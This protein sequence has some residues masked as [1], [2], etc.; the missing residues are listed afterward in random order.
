MAADYDQYRSITNYET[1][2]DDPLSVRVLRDFASNINNYCRYVALFKVL[3]NPC[4]PAWESHDNTTDERVIAIY[5]PRH[6][7]QG[8]NYWT[9]AYGHYRSAGSGSTTWRLYQSRSLY[10]AD[11][12]MDTDRLSSGYQSLSWT[13]NSAAHDIPAADRTM[14]IKRGDKGLCYF[15][16]TAENSDTGTRSKLTTLDA[17]PCII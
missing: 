8:Y 17:W 1:L 4:I 10:V 6:V 11:G 3:G 9:V 15:V 5:A 7:P 12:I 14:E 2:A 16:L 13:T